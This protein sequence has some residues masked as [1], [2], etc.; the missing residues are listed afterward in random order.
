MSEP[1][2][3]LQALS[4]VKGL[5]TM[6]LGEWQVAEVMSVVSLAVV[7]SSSP[8]KSSPTWC[9]DVVSLSDELSAGL[10]HPPTTGHLLI[11]TTSALDAF[12]L[13][14]HHGKLNCCFSSWGAF[15]VP[16]WNDF[17]YPIVTCEVNKN[18]PFLLGCPPFALN[19]TWTCYCKVWTIIFPS[20]SSIYFSIKPI[21][22]FQSPSCCVDDVVGWVIV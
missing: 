15:L 13:L 14:H 5:P 16:W 9:N 7:V 1:L 2:F 11:L 12:G 6:K 17:G 3:P 21:F 20:R 22:N 10:E 19:V 18:V 8:A 4:I